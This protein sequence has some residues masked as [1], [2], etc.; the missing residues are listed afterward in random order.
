VVSGRDAEIQPIP[1]PAFPL[2]G[3]ETSDNREDPS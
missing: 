3:K 2:K 1:I